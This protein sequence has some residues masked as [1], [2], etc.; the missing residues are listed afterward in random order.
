MGMGEVKETKERC[1]GTQAKQQ[2]EAIFT[3][4]PEEARGGSSESWSWEGELPC[5]S[6]G[7]GISQIM[8]EL[9]HSSGNKYFKLSCIMCFS[10][11]LDP[12]LTEPKQ[13]PESQRNLLRS[14]SSPMPQI[15]K[16]KRGTYILTLFYKWVKW[17][18]DR[19]DKLPKIHRW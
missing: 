11:L 18:S 14:A 2:W 7:H 15:G 16:K 1:W 8:T 17:D 6:C 19:L 9:Q 10:L 5:R 4:R 13:K 3:S 12:S